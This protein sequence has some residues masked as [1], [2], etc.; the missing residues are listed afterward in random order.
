MLI[1]VLTLLLC[2]N[3]LR[4]LLGFNLNKKFTLEKKAGDLRV[5]SWNVEHFEILKHKT[6]P[7]I[8]SEMLDIIA[9][10]NPDVACFQE[11]VG[12]ED[13]TDAINYLPPIMQKIGMPYMHYA[14]NKR[15]D[16]DDH[17]HFGIIILSK[18]PI[19]SQHM[20]SYAPNDYNSIFQYVDI[21]KNSD[22]IRVFNI[23][24]QS[25]KFDKETLQYLKEP[26]AEEKE[27]L[28]KSLGIVSKFKAGFIKRKWQSDRIRENVA[29]SPYPVILA[30]DFN[31]VPNSYAYHTIGQDLNNGFAK[32][33]AGISR[34]FVNISPTLRIDNIFASDR[35]TFSQYTRIKK[36]LSDHF[37]IIAD[38]RFQTA[39]Q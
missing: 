20:L 39:A 35:F 26:A 33:G 9:T 28:K 19:V 12:S 10:Y 29:L 8:K 3:P 17:H 34:T 27:N 21:A 24:L 30:G 2:I 31:D 32:K 11:M 4:H 22:T 36:E 15:L 5:M 13:K 14:Y 1:G 7:G 37:P 6:Q 38:L 25:L 16:F 23:H 18:Y